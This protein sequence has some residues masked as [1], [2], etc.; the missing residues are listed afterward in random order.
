[1]APIY[2]EL[3]EEFKDDESTVIAKMDSVANDI[4][5]PEYIVEGFPTIYFKPAGGKPMIYDKGREIADFITF[6][7]ENKAGAEKKEE[8]KT[9][10]SPKDEL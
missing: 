6:I 4:T 3:G 2:E 9:E 5:N 1:M 10:E 8:T 7:E